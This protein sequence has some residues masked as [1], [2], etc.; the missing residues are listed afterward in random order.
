MSH[1]V[2]VHRAQDTT[3]AE[4]VLPLTIHIG[5]QIPEPP[6]GDRLD[7]ARATFESDARAI[8]DALM[9]TLPGG[10]IDRVLA[11]LLDAKASLL[12]VRR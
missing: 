3:S 10:T 12:V 4:L 1:E 9:S 11:Y 5:E 6:L 7:R 8:V 2:H